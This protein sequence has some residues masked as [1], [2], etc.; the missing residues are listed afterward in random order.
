M[1]VRKV[2][3][4][5]VEKS[6]GS[7]SAVK[8]ALAGIE[9]KMGRDYHV[10]TL[11]EDSNPI[12]GWVKTGIW[13]L[14]FLISK[15]RGIP[16][17]RGL[18]VWGP[19]STGK[20]SLCDYFTWLFQ[21]LDGVALRLDYDD[22]LDEETMLRR[23]IDPDRVILPEPSCLEDGFDAIQGA[24]EGLYGEERL[25]K[26]QKLGAK[27]VSKNLSTPMIVLWDSLSAAPSRALA[28]SDSADK[29]L[30]GVDARAYSSQ[31][32][33]MRLIQRRRPLAM[34]FTAEI[35]EKIGGMPGWGGPQHNLS[36][37]KAVRHYPTT[38]LKLTGKKL[39]KVKRK[40]RTVTRGMWVYVTADKARKAKIGQS[41]MFYISFSTRPGEGGPHQA[42]SNLRFLK[43]NQLLKAK[44]KDGV[45]IRGLEDKVGV[46]TDKQ[47]PEVMKKH[48]KA[49]VAL[50]KDVLCADKDP[51]NM[52]DGGD[53]F[54]ND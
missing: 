38:I 4:K 25:K 44:G 35:R 24:V 3:R 19:E 30:V 32:K 9:N 29:S 2:S 15:F 52:D 49:I 43:D 26:G 47:W 13:P 42:I 48:E 50:L 6:D 37:G 27:G 51:V 36:G 18:I 17:G 16:L 14:D 1:P 11:K 54:E 34:V 23:G 33:K 46:F 10:V 31:L 7:D 12:V 41:S 22:A 39:D 53:D 28:E 20:S 21:Q 45:T 8:L 5:P 40:G